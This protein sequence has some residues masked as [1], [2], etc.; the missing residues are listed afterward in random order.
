MFRVVSS[1]FV[2]YTVAVYIIDSSGEMD[3]AHSERLFPEYEYENKVV[4]LD[5][6][7]EG[8]DMR[9]EPPNAAAGDTE[10]IRANNDW[11]QHASST[12]NK[13]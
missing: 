4:D 11:R 3:P 12:P 9:E 1:T 7:D 6:E 10:A 13:R 2:S 5:Q 8:G